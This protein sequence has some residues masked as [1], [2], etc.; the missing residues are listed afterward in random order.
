MKVCA[1]AGG[2]RG[3]GTHRGQMIKGLVHHEELV[4]IL[5]GVSG[6]GRVL[7]SDHPQREGCVLREAVIRC[8]LGP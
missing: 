6:G 3:G 5:Q 4:L 8:S 1:R 2:D 7:G